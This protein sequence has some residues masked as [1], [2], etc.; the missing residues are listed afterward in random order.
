MKNQKPSLLTLFLFTLLTF[1]IPVYSQINIEFERQRAFPFINECQTPDCRTQQS[2]PVGSGIMAPTIVVF[3][4]RQYT[5]GMYGCDTKANE[6]WGIQCVQILRDGE[7]FSEVFNF[8][9][10]V[11]DSY[12][13]LG[14]SRS[15]IDWA[16]QTPLLFRHGDKLMLVHWTHMSSKGINIIYAHSLNLRQLEPFTWEYE[17][18]YITDDKSVFNYLGGA[19]KGNDIFIAGYRSAGPLNYNR[20]ELI[21]LNLAH[22]QWAF[23]GPHPVAVYDGEIGFQTLYSHVLVLDNDEIR[24]LNSFYDGR[25]ESQYMNC[26]EGPRYHNIA[27]WKGRWNQ[28][29]PF[30]AVWSDRAAYDPCLLNSNDQIRFADDFLCVGCGDDRSDNDEVYALY[31]QKDVTSFCPKTTEAKFPLRK[32]GQIVNADIGRAFSESGISSLSMTHL[33]NSQFVFATT[34]GSDIQLQITSDLVNFLDEPIIRRTTF[35]G[36]NDIGIGN[37]IKLAQPNKN[38]SDGLISRLHIYHCG[39]IN[40]PDNSGRLINNNHRYKFYRASV[41]N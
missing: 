36:V 30:Q 18:S 24:I 33:A 2:I 34:V 16:Y 20:T 38:G 9:E 17:A 11:E 4:N 5:V 23:L 8:K 40:Y 7:P 21:N 25:S 31:R 22:G 32:N 15:D 41:S 14:T 26:V 29:H 13:P 27:E 28:A 12:F 6:R 19:M 3:Q 35:Q 37:Q 10:M 1:S 39:T